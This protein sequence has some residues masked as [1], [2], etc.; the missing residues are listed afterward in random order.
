MTVDSTNSLSSREDGRVPSLN[1]SPIT[2]PIHIQIEP[3][4]AQK[5]T[6]LLDSFRKDFTN[7][8]K[9]TFM[10]M[11]SEKDIN[12]GKLERMFSSGDNSSDSD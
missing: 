12:I 10:T 9:Q 7:K 6:S 1:Q 5:A 4:R 2:K 3:P 8:D 11:K